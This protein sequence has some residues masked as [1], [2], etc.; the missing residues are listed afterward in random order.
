MKKIFVIILAM[1]Q[2]GC[3]GLTYRTNE[4][5]ETYFKEKKK[6]AIVQP[7]MKIY[8]FTAGGVDQYQ[9]DWSVKSTKFM[10]EELRKELDSFDTIDFTYVDQENLDKVNNQFIE[11]QKAIYYMVASSVVAHTYEPKTL[12]KHKKINFDYTLGSELGGF[13]QIEDVEAIL[14][15][16]GRNYIWTAG[17]ASLAM[18]SGSVALFT[19]VY[20]PVPAGQEMLT[21]SLVDVQTGDILWFNYLAMPGDMRKHKTDQRLVK[22]LFRDF[23]EEWRNPVKWEVRKEEVVGKEEAVEKE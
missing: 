4:K 21:A 17:R 12:F 22:K 5:F 13:K 2:V 15:V 16:N 18:L 10:T 7:D 11:Q 14:F 23:P 8:R 19:G 3:A 20:L 9:D 6:V 1:S